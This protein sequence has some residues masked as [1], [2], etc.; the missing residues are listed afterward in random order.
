MLPNYS[1]LSSNPEWLHALNIIDCTAVLGGSLGLCP[2]APAAV[3]KKRNCTIDPHPSDMSGVTWSPNRSPLL[4][5]MLFLI[6][7]RSSNASL[8]FIFLRSHIGCGIGASTGVLSA[9]CFPTLFHMQ[10]LYARRI[11]T[12]RR[13]ETASP[14]SSAFLIPAGARLGMI[15]SRSGPG[16]RRDSSGIDLRRTWSWR[17]DVRV[18][19]TDAIVLL[20]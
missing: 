5:P 12:P 14:P 8:A 6:L 9:P 11:P 17:E 10:D 1:V 16:A 15:L 19:N 2:R 3:L 4:P 13:F 20:S 7:P 18:G